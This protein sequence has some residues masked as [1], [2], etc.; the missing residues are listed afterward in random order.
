M[1]TS[2]PI[3]SL[4]ALVGFGLAAAVALTMLNLGGDPSYTG[5][6]AN[7][8]ARG[9]VAAMAVDS[10]PP[11]APMAF[12]DGAGRTTSLADFHGRA[13]LL[14]LWATWCAPCVA[15]MPALDALQARLGGPSFQVVAVSLD[16]GGAAVAQAWMQR[17]GIRHLGVYAA[18]AVEHPDA[19]LPTSVLIDA[20]GRVA[21]TGLGAR[22][23]DA[24]E[25]VA[26]VAAVADEKAENRKG[27]GSE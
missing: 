6:P 15:E 9:P 17:N 26:A 13:I 23:W 11:A 22:A 20:R 27:D 12:A 1:N 8:S 2:G 25:V 5:S 16:R 10:R 24:P 18:D 21:W 19:M 4:A 7:P 3:K 14:N